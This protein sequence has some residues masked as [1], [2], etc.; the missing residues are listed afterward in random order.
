[1]RSPGANTA[2]VTLPE[3]GDPLG[4]ALVPDVPDKLSQP[5]TD[6]GGSQRGGRSTIISRW[7]PAYAGPGGEA[8][9]AASAHAQCLLARG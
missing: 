6:A 2:L 3:R 7:I 4:G 9:A 5:R 1:M 8:A